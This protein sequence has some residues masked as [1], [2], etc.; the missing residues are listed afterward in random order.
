[1]YANHRPAFGLQFERLIWA[2]DVVREK[3]LDDGEPE[4]AGEDE[5]GSE[6][7]EVQ[8]QVESEK[9]KSELTL[10]SKASIINIHRAEL[11]DLL[12]NRGTRF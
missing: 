11:L 7:K 10:A 8:L 4:E 9:K 3:F 5:E 2:F 6:E 1:M 12:Q